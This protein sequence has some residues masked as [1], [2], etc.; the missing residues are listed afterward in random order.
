MA[1]FFS[2]TFVKEPFGPLSEDC[3][4]SNNNNPITELE[5]TV[6][7]VKKLL[8]S[9]NPSKA[10]GPDRIHPKLL[11]SLS[12]NDSFVSA[13][14]VL[15]VKIY[16]TSSMPLQWKT[17][18]VIPLHKKGSK[19]SASNYRPVSLT[20]IL[21]KSYENIIREHIYN[22]V[23]AAITKR[24]HGFMPGRSCFS[25]LLETLDII[26]DMIINGEN[27]DIFYLDFQ[28]AFDTVPHYRLYVKLLSFGIQGKIL[29]TVFDFL[30][31]R[32]CKVMVGDN[33]SD[34]YNVTSGVPQGSVLGPLLFL[35][36]IN[37]IPDNIKNDIFI[38][39]DDLKMIA[40]SKEHQLNQNDL[41]S[42]VLWQEKWLLTFN[43]RDN[44]CKVMHVGKSNPHNQYQLEGVVLPSVESEKDLGVLFCSDLNFN[45]HISTCMKK[46]NSCIAWVTR[47]LISRNSEVMLKI[48]KSMIRPHLEYCVQLWSPLPSHG[49]WGVILAIENVQRKFTRL[50]DNIGLLPYKVRLEKL[51]LTTL[52]ERRARGDLI[53]TFK[54]VN[55]L[56]D[57][58]SNLFKF[59]RSGANLISKPGDQH[60]LRHAFF[61]RRVINYWNKLPAQVKFSKNIDN[62][63][64]NLCN[65]KRLHFHAQSHYW[66]LFKEIFNR[67][68]TNRSDYVTF[69]Q[70]NPG[71]ARCR[72][73][74]TR[75]TL[76]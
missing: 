3:Y 46:A 5:I 16:Q 43:T 31:D 29:N 21:C 32:T 58:G 63:K 22:H 6:E 38:F 64:N 39:A 13:I 23:K 34:S 70:D 52:L 54:I 61:S 66:E 28:K 72:G 2:T 44:K 17:A 27:V 24:Q 18:N 76:T 62:F 45:E 20:C 50:I 55:G 10:S 35:L 25:N 41:N 11:R 14:T 71:Y 49:N 26:Y 59:S 7:K 74:N 37:D 8:S 48:Y 67:I 36:Y 47:S 15:F 12:E 73:I 42:L 57:Y 75:V 4:I 33:K 51:G 65:F 60:K 53:E 19:T 40:K 1:E 9:V 68:D 69:V 56:S 30:S